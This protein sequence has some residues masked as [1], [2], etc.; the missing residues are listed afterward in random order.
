MLEV[1]GRP[2]E[3]VGK[4]GLQRYCANDSVATAFRRRWLYCRPAVLL[5]TCPQ[6]AGKTEILKIIV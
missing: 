1:A 3:G 6:V 2:A 4:G 5:E